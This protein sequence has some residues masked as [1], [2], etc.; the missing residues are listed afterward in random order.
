MTRSRVRT[1]KWVAGLKVTLMR[2]F[3]YATNIFE[4][5]LCGRCSVKYLVVIWERTKLSGPCLHRTCS[6]LEEINTRVIFTFMTEY[7][8]DHGF[9]RKVKDV[10]NDCNPGNLI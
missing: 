4:H 8:Q 5:L 9:E 1:G 6:L 7:Y 3:I 10:R 2:S